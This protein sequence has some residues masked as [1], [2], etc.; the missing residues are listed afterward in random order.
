MAL[1][2]LV[3]I[4]IIIIKLIT[5]NLTSYEAKLKISACVSTTLAALLSLFTSAASI[6]L[7]LGIKRPL[8]CPLSCKTNADYIKPHPPKALK[9]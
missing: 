4:I 7:V 3:I 8:R 6:R 1:R 5:V 9:K 2:R